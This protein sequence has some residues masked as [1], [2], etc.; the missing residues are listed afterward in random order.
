M[1]IKNRFL[2][3]WSVSILFDLLSCKKSSA[4][5]YKIRKKILSK[6][7]VR[8]SKETEFCADF[9]NVLK[10]RVWQK[11]KN[12]LQK[13]GRLWKMTWLHNVDNIRQKD[14]KTEF[15]GKYSFFWEKIFGY[16]LT[17]EF[18]TFLKSAQNS[19]SFDP[20]TRNFERIF[21]LIL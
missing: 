17:Q 16:F 3:Y 14:I 11:R 2:K 12:L 20:R 1:F 6:L 13:C 9:K 15:L 18:Y 5:P 19:A 4:T 10:S 8:V 21:F 7:R